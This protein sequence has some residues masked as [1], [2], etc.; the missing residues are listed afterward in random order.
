M[1]LDNTEIIIRLPTVL[2]LT[3]LSRTSVY[4]KM[5]REEFPQRVDLGARA[6]GWLLSEVLE[7]IKSRPRRR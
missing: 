6:V 1:E 7:W 4:R 5:E 2:R 3:G